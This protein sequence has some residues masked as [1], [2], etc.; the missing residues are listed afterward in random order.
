RAANA[1]A[2]GWADGDHGP[3][4]RK[5]ERSLFHHVAV[6]IRPEGDQ[7]R[8][9]AAWRLPLERRS[10]GDLHRFA[11]VQGQGPVHHFRYAAA[12]HARSKRER[13]PSRTRGEGCGA[14]NVAVVHRAGQRQRFAAEAHPIGHQ[15]GNSAGSAVVEFNSAMLRDASIQMRVRRQR[16]CSQA[17]L[18]LL[19][20]ILTC[21]ILLL[22]STLAL[23]IAKYAMIREKEATLRHNLDEG[24]LLSRESWRTWRSATPVIREKE[25][26][27]RHNLDEIREAIDRYK[28]AAD[29]NQIKVELETEGYPPDLETLVNGVPL[30]T[31][32]DKKIRFLRKIPIDPMTGHADWGL[33]A[34]QD[35]PDSTQ[36]GG[37][38]VFDVYSQ[39]TATAMD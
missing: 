1:H 30:G 35:D 24:W 37:K 4:R 28:D 25:A 32:G 15:R 26:T 11:T 12:Q 38:D 17:G 16:G 31:E 7:R 10:A 33:R 14:R 29:H 13:H 34:V 22:L 2:E 5:R 20:L 8:R 18:T 27:L 3:G 23:P 39:S 21:S 19:E 9:S 6:A 36:W